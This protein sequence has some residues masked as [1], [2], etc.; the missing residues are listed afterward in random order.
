MTTK[1]I[2][3]RLVELCREGKNDQAYDELFAKDAVAIE[4]AHSDAPDVKGVVALKEKAREWREGIAEFHK[5]EVSDPLVAR[6]FFT[7]T[8]K[9]DLSRKDGSRDHLEEICV[10]RV[11]NGKIA[12]ERFFY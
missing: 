3:Q 7:C 10:Y 9:V 11:E 8:M 5:V 6:N 4:P 1:E 12:V 2:A